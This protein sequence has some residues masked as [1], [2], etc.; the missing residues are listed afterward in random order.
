MAIQMLVTEDTST[1]IVLQAN[2]DYNE[3]LEKTFASNLKNG[4]GCLGI[5][6][7]PL[8]FILY[9]F[10]TTP[11][12]ALPWYFW[13]CSAAFFIAL[14]IFLLFEISVVNDIRTFAQ[15]T[16]V[17]VDLLSQ[18]ALRVEKPK[19]GR[20]RQTEINLSE[21]SRVLVDCQEVGHLCKLLLESENRPPFELN[22]AYDFEMEPLKELGK[23]LGRLINKPVIFRWAEG[24]TVEAEEA[25]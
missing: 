18:R 21:V 19:F 24:G 6:A 1:K 2:P 15:E 14:T 20:V 13:V 9:F 7:I 8:F 10:L 22:S 23:K 3:D 4:L 11:R 25:L 5:S 12:S 17:T 16:T